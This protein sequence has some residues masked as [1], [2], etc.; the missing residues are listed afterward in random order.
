MSNFLAIATVTEVLRQMLHAAVSEDVTGAVATAVRPTPGGSLPETG[1]NV[2][3]YQVTPN[4]AGR[5]TDLPT[6]DSDSAVVQRPRAALDLHYVLSFYGNES[7]LKPQR[8]MG[9]VVRAL[10]SQPVLTRQSI[11]DA[12]KDGYLDA[13]DL[14]NDV[15]LVK[16]TPSAFTLEELSKLWSVFF[17]TPYVLSVA[18]QASVVFIEA[19]QPARSA[20]PVLVRGV[21]ADPG[22]SPGG[23][24]LEGLVFPNRQVGIRTGEVLTLTGRQL[25]GSEVGARLTYLRGGERYTFAAETGGSS[26]QFNIRVASPILVPP[27]P[28]KERHLPI[29]V[30]TIAA[31]IHSEGGTAPVVTNELPLVLVPRIAGIS[32]GTPVDNE[33]TITVH[34]SP[35]VHRGQDVTLTLGDQAVPAAPFDVEHTS[36]LAFT[37]KNLATGDHWVRLRVDGIDSIL[38]DRSTDPPT[39]DPSQKVTIGS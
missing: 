28:L 25:A 6:R 13:A 8:V 30:Y 31:V 15:D 2:F 12:T 32:L 24:G 1:V 19:R 20:L 27:E 33:T 21:R 38:I 4:P 36:E 7:E 9:S 14:A 18:Y 16:F 10:H 39:F 23:P 11:R 37:F 22:L 34:C 29:G 3:L 5:N 35:D 17:Q 26:A